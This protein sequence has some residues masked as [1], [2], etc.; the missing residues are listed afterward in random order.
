MAS[1]TGCNAKCLR[2]VHNYARIITQERPTSIST[3]IAFLHSAQIE[4]HACKK[5]PAISDDASPCPKDVDAAATPHQK[6]HGTAEQ[7]QDTHHLRKADSAAN[8]ALVLLPK[9][10]LPSARCTLQSG[11]S[12]RYLP[13]HVSPL[14]Q[15]PP[16]SLGNSLTCRNRISVESSQRHAKIGPVVE[17]IYAEIFW[18]E[19]A[20]M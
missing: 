3:S 7:D 4:Q 19:G 9:F 6:P 1:T 2:G 16:S 17:E 8:S 10:Y 11:R 12:T 18:G 15:H 20:K 5:K 14:P 13:Y